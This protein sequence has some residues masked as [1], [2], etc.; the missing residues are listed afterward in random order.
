[1]KDYIV[2]E[3]QHLSPVVV[4]TTVLLAALFVVGLLYQFVSFL[5]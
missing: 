3:E 4:V 2:N 1:M 5:L